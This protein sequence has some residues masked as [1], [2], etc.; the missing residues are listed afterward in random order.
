MW[1]RSLARK[2]KQQTMP[3]KRTKKH[4][5]K[6]TA[7]V[8]GL[9]FILGLITIALVFVW[10][11]KDLPDPA[12]ISERKMKE[13]TR[14]YDRTGEVLLYDISGQER[15][16][17]VPLTEIPANMINATIATE[18]AN[19]YHHPG[20]DLK[21][22][23]RGA[24]LSLTGHS[25]QSGST[26]TQQFVK[27]SIL[28]SEKTYSRKIKEVI[29]S[30]ELELKYSKDQILELYLNQI[31]Y[32][33]NFY[34][35][36]AA[37]LGFFGKPIQKL[38][39]AETAVL[40][41]LP[42]AT[43][44]YSPYGNNPD[45]LKARQ[46][47][48][49][50]RMAALDMISPQQTQEAKAEKL[51]FAKQKY[52]ILAPHFVMYIKEYLE[53]KYGA[54]YVQQAGL[55]VYTTLDW[56]LQQVAQEAVGDGAASNEKRFN[57]K[58]AALVALDPKTGQ[59]LAMVG[60]RDYFDLENDGNVNVVLR[61]RQP[62][63]SFKPVVYATALQKGFTPQT[64]VFD[65]Q[66]NFSDDP[67]NPYI[68]QNYNGLFSGPVSLKTAL[69]Q[70][71]NIPAVKTLYLAGLKNVLN[72][73]QKTGFSTLNDER[74]FGLSLVL[75]GGEVKLL[76][77]VAAYGAFA[78][79]GLLSQPASI[80]KIV[81]QDGQTVEEFKP[82]TERVWET[83]TTRQI[84]DILSDNEARAPV[85]GPNSP[86]LLPGI[87][88]AVKTGTTDRYRD[89]WTVG[90]TPSLVAGVWVGN[91]NNQEMRDAPGV[92]AAAPLW[93]QFMQTAYQLKRQPMPTDKEV[94]ENY[95]PLPVNDESFAPPEPITVDKPMLNGNIFSEAQVAID[96][97]SGKLAT[98]FTP[99]ELIE[100]ITYKQAH[101]ILYYIDKDDPQGP[102]PQNP[103][104]DPQYAHWEAAVAA[105]LQNPE[106]CQ[107]LG[108]CIFNQPIPQEKDDVHTGQQKINIKIS[109]PPENSKINSP[110]LFVNIEIKNGQNIQ[111]ADFFI[112]DFLSASRLVTSDPVSSIAVNLDLKSLNPGSH[113][114][115]VRIYDQA[116]NFGEATLNFDYRPAS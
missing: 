42:R 28:T 79:E 88:T 113:R 97:V 15:R 84:N 104:G 95:F 102:A 45:K 111:Q 63:S 32:G 7:S 101:N 46:E 36:Q 9:L 55:S 23:L 91:N 21:G 58:N 78:T 81:D 26:I 57:A 66:T 16:F 98:E 94:P 39:L 35:V 13:S 65:V 5:L 54:D 115:K 14:I 60:S 1:Q 50:D 108:T 99:P 10:F 18:D 93:H 116:L 96:L 2:I 56:G 41:A 34:G 20:I 6:K 61:G 64:V 30:L 53:E 38:S 8:L 75:G 40:A 112:D 82:Q 44:Y 27:N 25:L 37:A 105:W 11:A 110:T 47:Y 59:I 48:I 17:F 114:L 24:Y 68:P 4:R 12:Q 19:F 100:T 52:A 3:K 33:S 109:N 69:A 71:L 29:L 80:L 74:R 106:N 107:K 62:G 51:E 89:A 43:T 67:Q 70:S 31:S 87:T 90:Y 103:N 73:A 22:M 92:S 72:Q 77:E 86:L 83:Q 85:F 76:E 49:L